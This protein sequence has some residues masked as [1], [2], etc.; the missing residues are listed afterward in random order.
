MESPSTIVIK[1]PQHFGSKE[2]RK[3]QVELKGHGLT[4]ETSV[5][6]DLSQVRQINTAGVDSLLQCIHQVIKQDGSVRL[7]EISAEASTM[8]E[9]IGMDHIF[10]M[11]PRFSE[12]TEEYAEEPFVEALE[13][14]SKPSPAV[15][16]AQTVAA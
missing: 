7:S 1:L 4:Y 10:E 3:L 12:Q 6:F 8:L 14:D 13:P 16:A 2:A 15:P 5:V 9:L 11:F